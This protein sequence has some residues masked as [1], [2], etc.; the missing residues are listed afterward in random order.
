M[1]NAAADSAAIADGRVPN[2]VSSFYE[3]RQARC[4]AGVA[5]DGRVAGYGTE[6]QATIPGTHISQFADAVDIDEHI[7]MSEAH[8]HQRDEALAPCQYPRLL[9]MFS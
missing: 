1:S 3:Q 7:G 9:C 2:A 5:L 8:I 6:R 4:G